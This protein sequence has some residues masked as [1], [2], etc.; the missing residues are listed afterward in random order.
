MAR[1]RVKQKLMHGIVVF[2]LMWFSLSRL[3]DLKP[4]K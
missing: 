3:R 2:V 1:G 4:L